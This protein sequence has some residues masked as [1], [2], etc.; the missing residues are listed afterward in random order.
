FE[1]KPMMF[2]AWDI[3]IFYQEKMKEVTNLASVQFM[4]QGSLQTVIRFKWE[5]GSSTITQD[6]IVYAESR[7]IDFKT[8]VDWQERQRLL[9]VAFPVDVLATDA[10]YDILYGIVKL[11][12]LLNSRCDLA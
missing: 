10:I 1:D 4:E 12:S 7:R 8:H 9:N 6:M 3:D 5:F 2:D 11:S